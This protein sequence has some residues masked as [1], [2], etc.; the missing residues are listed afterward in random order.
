[1]KKYDEAVKVISAFEKTQ[2]APSAGKKDFDAGELTLLKAE[3]L[4]AAGKQGE[5]LKYLAKNDGHICDGLALR[6]LRGDL[7]LQVGEKYKAEVVF[8]GLLSDNVENQ[9]YYAK[10]EAAMGIDSST[11]VSERA[12]C[13]LFI[14]CMQLFGSRDFF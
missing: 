5:A 7:Y 4:A 2:G 6:E 10:L 14:C 9:G 11:P 3:I 13:P 12:V 8:R 1:M